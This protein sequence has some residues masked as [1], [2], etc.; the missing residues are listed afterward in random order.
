MHYSQV[1]NIAG[2][3]LLSQIKVTTELRSKFCGLEF[4]MLLLGKI[5][6]AMRG[7]VNTT[8][9]KVGKGLPP[10]SFHFKVS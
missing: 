4:L 10:L 9:D 8:E 1:Q 7:I 3:P 2:F 6:N 5:N